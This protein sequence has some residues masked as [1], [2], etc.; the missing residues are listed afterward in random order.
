MRERFSSFMPLPI[1][2]GIEGCDTGIRDR[3]RKCVRRIQGLAPEERL[4]LPLLVDPNHV[5]DIRRSMR[6]PRVCLSK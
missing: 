6:K 4:H 3:R 2:R 5:R 1:N